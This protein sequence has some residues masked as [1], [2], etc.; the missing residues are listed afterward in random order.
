MLIVAYII[1][2]F[3]RNIRAIYKVLEKSQLFISS[4]KLHGIGIIIREF[5]W[6]KFN[7]IFDQLVYQHAVSV[8][9][10]FVLCSSLSLYPFDGYFLTIL[11]YLICWVIGWKSFLCYNSGC[12]KFYR[13]NLKLITVYLQV[14]LSYFLYKNL[15]VYSPF[16]CS[17]PL[18]FHC[19]LFYIYVINSN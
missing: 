3:S 9:L 13:I 7:V 5:R 16:L 17:W 11:F 14:I 8:L 1:Y 19:H 4:Q 15:V 12:F 18:C 6:F 10:P 2:N